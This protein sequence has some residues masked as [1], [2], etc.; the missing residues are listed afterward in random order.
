M[1]VGSGKQS[2]L[3]GKLKE[4]ANPPGGYQTQFSDRLYYRKH[5]ISLADWCPPGQ[6]PCL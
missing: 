2:Q 3:L 1:Q 6:S 5:W 4:T